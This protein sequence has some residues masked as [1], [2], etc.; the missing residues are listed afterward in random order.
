MRSARN[1]LNQ[2]ALE[3]R[4]HLGIVQFANRLD[5]L[6]RCRGQRVVGTAMERRLRAIRHE[7]KA[8]HRG[9]GTT[10]N[11]SAGHSVSGGHENG[12]VAE[13]TVVWLAE[14]PLSSC[15]GRL[16]LDADHPIPDV[17]GEKCL[18]ADHNRKDGTCEVGAMARPVYRQLGCQPI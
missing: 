17:N 18:W 8:T 4:R 11:S 7:D 10:V 2:R 15:S 1:D 16:F 12:L 5:Q 14:H 13:L 6:G 9:R 3:S